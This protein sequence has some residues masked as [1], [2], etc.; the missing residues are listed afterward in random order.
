MDSADP[1]T[2]M[3]GSQALFDFIAENAGRAPDFWGRYIGGN[4]ALVPMEAQFLHNRGCKILII[5]NGTHNSPASVQGGYQEGVL[6]AT[7]AITAAQGLGVPGG[8][9]IYADIE[10]S[11][12]PTPEWFKGWSDTMLTSVYGGAG[13]V[14]GNPHPANSANFNI[15]YCAA[16]TSDPNMQGDV[17]RAAHVYSSEPQPGCTSAANAPAYVP[18]NP[19][20]NPKTVIWQ[21]AEGCFNGYVDEDLAN[22]KGFS[23]MW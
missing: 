21:Y 12:K 18:M 14:Y 1:V 7:R 16:Y 10:A 20:C 15:P 13:G 19:P 4:Y 2:Q 17:D 5:Y 3:V 22:D 6:D 11:W 23:S 9:W 8:T